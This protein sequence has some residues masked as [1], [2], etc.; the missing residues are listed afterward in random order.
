MQP[1]L[2]SS[3][4][5]SCRIIIGQTPI[6]AIGMWK[7]SSFQWGMRGRG[8]KVNSTIVPEKYANVMHSFASI[9]QKIVESIEKYPD[10]SL[11]KIEDWCA[12]RKLNE[13]IDKNMKMF[14]L[15]L[16]IDKETLN[17]FYVECKKTFNE[18]K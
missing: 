11:K 8:I 2:T 1:Q 16:D 9:P 7:K 5:Q 18:V 3:N 10:E 14:I 17:Q 4:K 6:T 12:V 15:K 13:P